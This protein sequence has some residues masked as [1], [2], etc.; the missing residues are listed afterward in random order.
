M[1]IVLN[2]IYC[3]VDN[4]IKALCLLCFRVWISCC[5]MWITLYD[6]CWIM[7]VIHIL[8]ISYVDNYV[9]NLQ[10]DT[11]IFRTIHRDSIY[12]STIY[13]KLSS[14]FTWQIFMICHNQV[15]KTSCKNVLNTTYT[16]ITYH[17]SWGCIYIF[18][19][20]IFSTNL[21]MCSTQTST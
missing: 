20:P 16:I 2:T 6:G 19:I 12:C 13:K 3:N 7:W 8:W 1:D 15:T 17:I 4:F 9:D 21:G 14:I 10:V 5:V 18:N 11:C